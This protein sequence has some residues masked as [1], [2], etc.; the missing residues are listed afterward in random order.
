MFQRE[1][2]AEYLRG[3]TSKGVFFLDQDLPTDP[4]ERDSLLLRVIGSPDPYQKQV[5][6]MGGATSSTSKVVVLKKSERE[7]CDVDYL[8]GAVAVDAPVID[9]SGNCGNLTSAVGPFAIRNGLVEAPDNGIATITIW[10][11]NIQK[12]I[13]AKVPMKEGQVQELGDFQLD[14]VTF[15]AAEIVLEFLDAGAD[16]EGGVFPTGQVMDIVDVPGIGPLTVTMMNAGNPHIFIHAGQLGLLGTEL[17][18]GFNNDASLLAKCEQIRAFCTVKMGMA[19]T[20]EE[21][22]RLRPHTPKLAFVSVPQ[23][24]EASSGVEVNK[25]NIDL[26]AR[27]LSMGK[28]HHAMTGTGG[29]GLAAAAAVKGTVV[30]LVVG[31]KAMR[32]E[33]INIGHSSGCMAVGALASQSQEG[34]WAIEKVIMSRSARRLMAGSVL[35]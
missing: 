18:N 11:Q 12:K 33:Q 13:V 28:L 17:P 34:D 24:Y 26:V 19:A 29:V 10:Q 20:P 3:G 9:W 15:P 23:S 32:G 31:E 25:E 22:T 21:A 8:F 1:V 27:I 30:Q 4:V 16:G 7:D 6:G 14:G 2:R 35:V 5:D